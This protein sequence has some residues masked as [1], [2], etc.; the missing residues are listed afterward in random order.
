MHVTR[1]KVTDSKMLGGS[2]LQVGAMH[3]QLARLLIHSK[4]SPVSSQFECEARS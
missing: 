3:E 2:F 4:Q 1:Q